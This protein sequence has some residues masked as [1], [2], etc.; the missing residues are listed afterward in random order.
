[1]AS[2]VTGTSAGN[3]G[4]ATINYTSL[5]PTTSWSQLFWGPSSSALPKAG[6]D[7]SLHALAFNGIN[8]TSA[9]WLGTTSWTNPTTG[10]THTGVQIGVIVTITGLGASP[11]TLSNTIPQ[12]DPGVGTGI[13]AVV[14]DAAG[15]PFS[16]NVQVLADIPTD[17]SGNFIA[18]N[19]IQNGG[20]K[21]VSSFTGGF[22]TRVGP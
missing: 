17:G 4:G 3:A 6:L 16:A 19:T 1:M 21:T 10:I 2:N 9:S 5:T 12:L 22:Y 14:S 7:G 11:W 8:G 18:V 20:G 15:T 13:G